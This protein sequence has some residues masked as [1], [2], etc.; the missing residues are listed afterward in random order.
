MA[1]K[2]TI[3]V[4]GAHTDDFVIGAGGTIAK[5]IEE[6]K[7]VISVVFSLGELSHFWL[8]DH[9]I[10][11][12]RSQETLVAGEL[13]GC[14]TIFLKLGD[15]KIQE[16]YDK[17][18]LEEKLLK[19]LNK[20]KPTKIFTHS[21]EDPHPDH[22]TVQR[23]TLDLY[24]KVNFQPKPEVYVYSVWNPVSF[25]TSWPAL[26]VDVRKT[27]SRKLDA[28][29]EFKSQKVHVAYPFILLVFRAI[30]NGIKIRTLFAEKF[31][32]IK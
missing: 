30:K 8:K 19:I 25:K 23:I 21:I 27:F 12:I 20:E 5:Y 4:F 26:Y 17:Y 32:R 24:E 10:K 22:K 16:D 11:G 1:K 18:H 15:Q 3:F 14:E 9:V 31:F 2:E 29:K 28:L 7:K 13:M 6:G